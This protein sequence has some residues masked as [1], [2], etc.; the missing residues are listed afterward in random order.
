MKLT[1]PSA[2]IDTFQ[3]AVVFLELSSIWQPLDPETTSRIKYAKY[4]AVRIAKAIKAG[5]DPNASNPVDEM[6]P[7][8]AVTGA[9]DVEM[10]S[11]THEYKPPSV[12]DAPDSMQPSRPGSAPQVQIPSAPR[13]SNA[14]PDVSPIEPAEDA[15]RQGSVGG[16]YF[17]AVPTFTSE[18]SQPSMPTVGANVPPSTPSAYDRP[19]ALSPSAGPSTN[20]IATPRDFYTQ[21]AAQ[22]PPTVAPA[23]PRPAPAPQAA[24]RGAYLTDDDSIMKAQKHAK[25]AMSALNFEDVDT[26]VKE[27]RLALQ[28]LG[29]S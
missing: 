2:T 10:T 8:G 29:A 23:Q 20:G 7:Q 4:H 19:D 6:P 18:T 12:E 13:E 16:G 27:L 28:T 24:P 9:E 17:P 25:W 5:E 11:P 15:S 3:A 26:A 1:D 21:P 14:E 22:P